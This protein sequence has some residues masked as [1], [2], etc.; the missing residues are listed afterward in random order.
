MYRPLSPAGYMDFETTSK[1]GKFDRI[2][3]ERISN[4]RATDTIVYHVLP[5][6]ACTPDQF[7][8]STI[9]GR[10]VKIG[11]G[12]YATVS[13]VGSNEAHHLLKHL[14]NLIT[15]KHASEIPK[16]KG[17]IIKVFAMEDEDRALFNRDDS[18]ENATK[19]KESKR[20]AWLELL[21]DGALD[22]T[23]H[24]FITSAKTVEIPCKSG[25]IALRGRDVVPDFYFAGSN[26]QYGVY[27]IAMGMVAGS[28]MTS[29][30]DTPEL[31]ANLEKAILTLAAIGVEHGD[32]H[33]GNILVLQRNQVKI[34]D[35][36]MTAILPRKYRE[37]NIR[38]TTKAVH[39]LMKEGRWPEYVID[40]IWYNSEE[41][42][43]RYL[44]SYLAN[45][46]KD[47]FD[48][49]NPTS[50]LLLSKKS[51]INKV[52]LDAARLQAWKGSCIHRRV[53]PSTQ[54]N[55]GTDGAS[56]QPTKKARQ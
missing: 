4:K 24:K 41:G 54:S 18:L 48:W 36:G 50:K 27:V 32:L 16:D 19:L 47:S 12:K 8:K 56:V 9:K 6:R 40:S 2:P 28:N 37:K 21:H 7:T 20:K 39:T 1:F 51:K 52:L 30:R 55:A 33:T 34:I 46:Y 43:A 11:K 15:S 49:Y 23:N 38:L 22:A 14:D 3:I 13:M 35:F 53:S 17:M 5:P 26:R 42:V 31:V 45:K 25:H 10:I 29:H 44:D